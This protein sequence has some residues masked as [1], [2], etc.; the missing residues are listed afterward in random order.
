MKELAEKIATVYEAFQKDA[1]AQVENCN[2][3]CYIFYSFVSP[4]VIPISYL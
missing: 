4:D 2:L 1:V 3:L